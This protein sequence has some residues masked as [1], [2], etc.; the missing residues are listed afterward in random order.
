MASTQLPH[1]PYN[2]IITGVGGQGN[3]MVS[4]V[5]ANMLVKKGYYVT[6]GE[7]FGASQRGGSVMSHLRVSKRSSWSPQIPHGR[8]HAVIALEPIEGIRVLKDYGNLEVSMLLNTRPIYPVAVIAG[9]SEYP[10]IEK[11]TNSAQDLASKVWFIDATDEAIKLG[12][13]I[14]GNIVMLGAF[15]GV[16]DLPLAEEDFKEVILTTILPDKLDINL[17]AYDIGKGKI[18]HYKEITS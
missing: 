16:S 10:S 14:L 7:T 3:V 4:R 13:P 18:G 15:S 17:K 11:I 5:L 9:E 12:N 8:A 6:I 1:D 2:I